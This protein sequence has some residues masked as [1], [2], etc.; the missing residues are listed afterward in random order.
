MEREYFDEA[1]TYLFEAAY[2]DET[3]YQCEIAHYRLS[4]L[5]DLYYEEKT[6]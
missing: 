6:R 5:I 4:E 1:L 3:A 2:T